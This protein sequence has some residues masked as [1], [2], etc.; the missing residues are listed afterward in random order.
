[1]PHTEPARFCVE[2]PGLLTTVQDLGRFGFQRFGMPVGGAM[3]SVAVRLANRLVGNPDEAAALEITV[4]GPELVFQT[5]AIIAVTGADLS[6]TINLKPV[7]LWT[8]LA[9]RYGSTLAFGARRHGARAYV[10]VAGGIDVP[11]VLSS[12]ATHIQSRTGGFEGRALV[13]GDTVRC[14]HPAPAAS[15]LL[16]RTIPLT[17]RPPYRSDPTLRAVL[18]PQAEYFLKDAVETLAHQR[19]TVCSQSDRMGYRLSG[20]SL[21]HSDASDIV[22]DATPPG[23][24]QV[25]ANQQPILLMADRQTTGGY[26]K[27]AVVITVDLPL[28]AQLIPGDTIGFSLVDVHEARA[29]A[30][31]HWAALKTAVPE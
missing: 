11:V 23:S 22:S 16:G 14:G 4:Q 31:H 18:G 28:A 17:A 1:M 21:V 26:P 7:A 6:P 3:D 30:R 25:P 20:P 13:R 5:D 2:R 19:Y 29:I 9:V 12:R 10:A 27:I 8:T 15:K 24:L